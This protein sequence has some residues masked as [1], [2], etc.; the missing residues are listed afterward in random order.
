MRRLALTFRHA[1]AILQEN[2]ACSSGKS[3]QI[4]TSIERAD[5]RFGSISV[6]TSI[7]GSASLFD[8]HES[9]ASSLGTTRPQIEGRTKASIEAFSLFL[10]NFCSKCKPLRKIYFIGKLDRPA[11]LPATGCGQPAAAY[12]DIQRLRPPLRNS[13]QRRSSSASSPP[14]SGPGHGGSTSNK[15]LSAS[16]MSSCRHP[17]PPTR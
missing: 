1:I 7:C 8:D 3:L 4:C 6:S 9:G 13:R 11:K 14:P 16:S 17:P 5:R 2:V 10:T 12:A 15:R